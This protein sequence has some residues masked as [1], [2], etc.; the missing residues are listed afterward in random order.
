MSLKEIAKLIRTATSLPIILDET[1]KKEIKGTQD[2]GASLYEKLDNGMENSQ[3]LQDYVNSYEQSDDIPVNFKG[4][5]SDFLNQVSSH[6]DSTWRYDNGMI[7]FSKYQ[8]KTF[9]IASLPTTIKTTSDLNMGLSGSVPGSSGSG[10][11]SG[12]GGDS[13]G[14]THNVSV[15]TNLTIWDDIKKS[16]RIIIEEREPSI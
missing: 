13:I 14:V 15:K 1:L 10:S 12:S 4:K 11:G 5:L 6:Y 16:I 3:K 7:I 9:T 2:D 8:V